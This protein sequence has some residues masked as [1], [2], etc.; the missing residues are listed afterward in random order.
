[1]KNINLNETEFLGENEA[2]VLEIFRNIPDNRKLEALETLYTYAK[3]NI[4]KLEASHEK[5]IG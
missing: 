2:E 3:E 4:E 5:S 1:M